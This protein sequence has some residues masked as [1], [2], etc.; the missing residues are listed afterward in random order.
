[1]QLT[2]D[3]EHP[4]VFQGPA[5]MTVPA[6]TEASYALSFA[7][8]WMGKYSATLVLAIP[9]T[10]ETN[11]YNLTGHGLEPCATDHIVLRC[12]A[13]SHK[14]MTIN[15]PNQSTAA[16]TFQV[17]SD[18]AGIAGPDSVR[19][20]PTGVE[21]YSFTFTPPLS[22][23]FAGTLTFSATSGQYIWY[24]VEAIVSAAP[25]QETISVCAAGMV[26]QLMFQQLFSLK[27]PIIQR[28]IYSGI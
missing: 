21:A 15:V 19:V 5:E 22:G 1:V 9:I 2:G 24:S 25:K 6:G 8:P 17:F 27:T 11:T 10:L 26:P 23:S 3:P 4:D 28:F 13:R 20:G 18:L 14:T 12:Q 16:E 7:P